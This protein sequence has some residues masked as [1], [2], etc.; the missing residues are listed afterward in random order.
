MHLCT[1]YVLESEYS[2]VL[3]AGFFMSASGRKR[4][5]GSHLSAWIE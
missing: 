1:L 5:F 2:P 4:P 3:V